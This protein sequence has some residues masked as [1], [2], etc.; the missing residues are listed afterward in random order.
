MSFGAYMNSFYS[1][2][3]VPKRSSTY[4]ARLN[5]SVENFRGEVMYSS[6]AFVTF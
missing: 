4:T 2:E 5:S 6:Q 3:S 1:F